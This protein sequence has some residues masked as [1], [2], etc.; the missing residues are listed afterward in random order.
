[1]NL[2]TK[3]KIKTILFAVFVLALALALGF[4]A[5]YVKALIFKSVFQIG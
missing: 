1:M 3:E 5:Y 2:Y 4:G